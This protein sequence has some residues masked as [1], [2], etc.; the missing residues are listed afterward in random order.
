MKV[1]PISLA[2]EKAVLEEII[3]LCTRGLMKY[4]TSLE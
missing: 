4:E 2:N 3:R 1:E